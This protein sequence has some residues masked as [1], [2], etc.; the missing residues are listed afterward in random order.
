MKKEYLQ[1]SILLDEANDVIVMSV[2]LAWNADWGD[3][4]NPYP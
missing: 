4:W 2:G 3:D 1:P